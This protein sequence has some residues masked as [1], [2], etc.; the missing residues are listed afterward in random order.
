MSIDCTC[1]NG[2]FNCGNLKINNRNVRLYYNSYTGDS[3]I[4]M[5]YDPNEKE[6]IYPKTIEDESEFYQNTS[7]GLNQTEVKTRKKILYKS[8]LRIEFETNIDKFK[9]IKKFYLANESKL[10]ICV[11]MYDIMNLSY[12]LKR[13]FD[14]KYQYRVIDKKDVQS[15]DYENY[16]F[17][18]KL[19]N[20][21]YKEQQFN[22]VISNI[23]TDFLIK[24]K[25]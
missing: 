25:E 18:I 2:F 8:K 3:N 12:D 13:F 4:F 6:F 14:E 20:L 23:T 9:Y 1:M 15:Y 22:I 19:L 7:Q 5:I 10:L 11:P 24:V 17:L 21:D 16:L